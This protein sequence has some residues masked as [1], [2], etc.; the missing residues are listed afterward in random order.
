MTWLEWEGVKT[1]HFPVS[2][3]EQASKSIRSGLHILLAEKTGFGE[4]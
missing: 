1:L 4:K 3:A 2:N